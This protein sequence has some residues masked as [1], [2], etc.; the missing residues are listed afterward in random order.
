MMAKM[1]QQQAHFTDKAAP[2]KPD[3]KS[4]KVLTCSLLA[5]LDKQL[6]YALLHDHES[7]A[8]VL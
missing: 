4:S 6:L 8:H 1:R 3:E 2:P 5:V 7:Q